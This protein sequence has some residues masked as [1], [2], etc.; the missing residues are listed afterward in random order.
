M[1]CKELFYNFQNQAKKLDHAR[2]TRILS[3]FRITKVTLVFMKQQTFNKMKIIRYTVHHSQ[4][5]LSSLTYAPVFL[6]KIY[7][8]HLS[9]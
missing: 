1:D 3:S 4:Q 9:S 6:I 2:V 5:I 8:F 7:N